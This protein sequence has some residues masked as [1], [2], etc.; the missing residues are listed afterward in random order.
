MQLN[1]RIISP[2]TAGEH[3]SHLSDEFSIIN[4][5]AYIFPPF[6]ILPLASK[7]ST[8]RDHIA[9]FVTDMDGTTT[10]TEE[11]C[12]YSLEFMIRTMSGKLTVGDWHGLD[13]TIDY[14]YVIG[15]STTKH[16]EFLINRYSNFINKNFTSKA[17]IKAMVWQLIFGKDKVRKEEIINNI[18]HFKLDELLTDPKFEKLLNTNNLNEFNLSDELIYL[19]QNYSPV[20]DSLNHSVLVKIGIDIYYYKYHEILE[21]LK[22]GKSRE[23]ALE[24]FNDENKNLIEPMPGIGIFLALI[25]GWLGDNIQLFVN[26]LIDEYKKKS[27]AVFI[28]N[29][30][31]K[32]I[33]DLIQL[34]NRFTNQPAKIGIVTSSIFFEADIVLTELFNV[35]KKQFLKLD[36]ND[37]IKQELAEKFTHYSLVYDTIATASDTNEIRLKP[38]RDLYSIALH[39]LHIPK[40]EFINVIG[41]EDSESGTI[42]IRAAGIGFCIAVPFTQTNFHN[43]D[44]ASVIA[45]GGLPELILRHKLFL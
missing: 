41:M 45:Y 8:K 2:G 27:N 42:A 10:T 29:D 43:F 5:P 38:H 31:E 18:K 35:I 1:N 21:R 23:I 30:K 33:A 15:N 7:I 3:L 16:V 39:N 9:A 37:S 40:N 11:L 14:P 22:S 17:L 12:L 25:K 32:L 36:L 26:L 28:C 13:K 24:L 19:M 34:A 6:E 20:F 44:A 4:N